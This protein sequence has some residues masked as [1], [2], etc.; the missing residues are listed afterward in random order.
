MLNIKKMNS[1]KILNILINSYTG[2][3]LIP[4]LILGIA[5]QIVFSTS[6]KKEAAVRSYSLLSS[7]S[8][9]TE[10]ILN[11][12][13]L[14]LEKIHDLMESGIISDE[15]M[16]V[17]FDEL[18]SKYHFFESIQ[19]ID[20]GGKLIYISPLNEDLLGSDMS[21]NE[22]YIKS[23]AIKYPFWS[24]TFI[25]FETGNPTLALSY[26]F[27]NGL[28][29]GFLNLTELKYYIY[30]LTES[31]NSDL[32][33]VD[34]YGNYLVHKDE[35]KVNERYTEYQFKK[36]NQIT[37]SP[38]NYLLLELEDQKYFV[39]AIKIKTSGWN[40]ISYQ[41]IKMALSTVRKFRIG[42]IIGLIASVLIA[43]AYAV[44]N[45]RRI[46]RPIN[47]LLIQT[48]TM[49]QGE[50]EKPIEL[51][52]FTEIN[53]L[54]ESF[55]DMSQAI[56][57]RQSQLEESENRYRILFEDNMAIMIQI[58]PINFNILNVNK[59]AL[60]YY[61][62]SKEQFSSK[63]LN[64]IFPESKDFEI[65][66][67][68]Q[69]SGFNFETK[70]ATVSGK[71]K[72]VEIYGSRISYGSEETLF[73]IIHDISKRKTAE[74]ELIKAKDKAEESDRLKSAFLANMSH[75]IRT[76]MNA[77][78][79][80]AGLIQKTNIDDS[81][82]DTYLSIINSNTK[83]LLAIITDIIDISKIESRQ[84]RLYPKNISVGK[85]LSL[86]KQQ[87]ENELVS[88]EKDQLKIILDEFNEME[89]FT[90]EVRVKQILSNL[91]G[92]AIKFTKS[93]QINFG[94]IKENTERL[95]F[96]V[97]D[98]GVGITKNKQKLIFE[99][100]RQADERRDQLIGGTGLGLSISNGL[101]ELMNGKIWL[102]SEE[103]KGS[104]FYFTIP[105][106]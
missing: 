21:Y 68:K 93:G 87:F 90:D 62:I 2:I 86:L 84:L 70:T 31:M 81:T 4:I 49:A 38:D 98:T 94:I 41:P 75:E 42:F 61:T 16:N 60:D 30:R 53:I 17:L 103:N 67:N 59:A 76:P 36:I 32:A 80:F 78:I 39:N 3:S 64:E 54:A 82:K 95:T 65:R 104:T 12:R 51:K 37:T 88:K 74:R 28:I 99:Q 33:I 105:I 56:Q 13:L 14:E 35:S 19:F 24:S 96:Y 89:I 50:Y 55:N 45:V 92:N 101:V 34:S 26:P 83:Q 46:T 6:I 72:D 48:K 85:L 7:I 97:K 25:S 69:I 29:V 47:K 102:E 18:I 15:N 79:G 57:H 1:R 106:K 52:S 8:Y 43:I 58:S 66:L 11:K 10:D 91:L 63:S 9:Y 71:L 27:E 100:F 73:L 5:V 23:L 44:Q 40:V 77:I 20:N 22:Y